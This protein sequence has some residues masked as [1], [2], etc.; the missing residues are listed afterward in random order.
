M[1]IETLHLDEDAKRRL[2]SLKRRTGISQWNILSRWAFCTSLA[3]GH[4]VG[5]LNNAPLSSVEMTWKVFSGQNGKV[6][7]ALA[8]QSQSLA[9]KTGFAG[10]LHD[11]VT[12][13]IGHGA[14]ILMAGK[15]SIKNC[16]SLLRKAA[17]G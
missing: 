5:A 1:N 4:V 16:K 9:A 13:H 11:T 17:S 3:S 8:L 6:Y 15:T 12:Q 2:I 10:S 14:S 7:E